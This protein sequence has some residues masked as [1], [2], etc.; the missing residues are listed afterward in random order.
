V[1][2]SPRQSRQTGRLLLIAVFILLSIVIGIASDAMSSANE[3]P[4]NEDLMQEILKLRP[5][6][7]TGA[8]APAAQSAPPADQ[9]S[10]GAG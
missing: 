6:A 9:P 1:T 10:Q 3:R 4:T 5:S 8:D 7:P 2:G